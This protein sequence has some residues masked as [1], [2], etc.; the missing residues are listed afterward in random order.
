MLTD[1]CRLLLL[2]ILKKCLWKHLQ[3]AIKCF[4]VNKNNKIYLMGK[5]FLYFNFYCM[6]K[7]HTGSHVR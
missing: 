1:F 5:M 7:H 6:N 4:R 3:F 2:I